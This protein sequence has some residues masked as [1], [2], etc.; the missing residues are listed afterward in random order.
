[1]KN[2][3][4]LLSAELVITNKNVVKRANIV[5]GDYSYYADPEGAEKFEERVTH[6]YDFLGD[7]LHSR[8]FCAIVRRIEFVMN[9][10]NQKMC[11]ELGKIRNIKDI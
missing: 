10:A 11:G 7:R 3:L 6:H 4:R 1:M 5:V 8:K 2:T 9:G